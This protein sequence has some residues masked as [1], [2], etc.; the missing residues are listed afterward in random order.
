M[1]VIKRPKMF[2]LFTDGERRTHADKN[3][4]TTLVSDSCSRFHLFRSQAKMELHVFEQLFFHKEIFYLY[5]WG[6]FVV[7][8][9]FLSVGYNQWSGFLEGCG[10]DEAQHRNFSRLHNFPFLVTT[11]TSN[12][13]FYSDSAGIP[14]VNT[15]QPFVAPVFGCIQYYSKHSVYT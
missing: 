2:C 5:F 9:V 11:N 3:I 15:S 6:F 14:D 1:S 10:V 4:H 7:S 8:S 13:G 12:C